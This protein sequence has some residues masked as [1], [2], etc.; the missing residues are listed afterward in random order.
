MGYD[1]PL[2]AEEFL[3]LRHTLAQDNNTSVLEHLYNELASM[4]TSDPDRAASILQ[5]LT[6][7]SDKEERDT[8]AIYISLLFAT[9]PG[10]ARELLVTLLHDSD[11]H[12]RVQA[13]DTLDAVISDNR[14]TVAD[15]ARLA[16][17]AQN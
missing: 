7:S 15:A 11:H 1:R 4:V 3:R 13:L 8:A 16:T 14:I 17:S 5:A 10:H 12:V 9:R 6:D 2:T